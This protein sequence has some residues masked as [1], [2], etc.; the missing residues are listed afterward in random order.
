MSKNINPFIIILIIILIIISFIVLLKW[1]NKQTQIGSENKQIQREEQSIPST[2]KLTNA[3]Q[4]ILDMIT[5]Q[6]LP[7]GE[8]LPILGN[9]VFQNAE[10]NV[11]SDKMNVTGGIA[12]LNFDVI[13]VPTEVKS[14]QREKIQSV[15]ND[16]NIQYNET[17]D[18]PSLQTQKNENITT[19]LNKLIDNSTKTETNINDIQQKIFD[20]YGPE[21]LIGS[22]K[23]D[24]KIDNYYRRRNILNNDIIY[25]K[26]PTYTIQTDSSSVY[27]LFPQNRSTITETSQI[28][29]KFFKTESI[30][31]NDRIDD[32][33]AKKTKIT[34]RPVFYTMTDLV[35]QLKMDN[36]K[37]DLL[38]KEEKILGLRN[39]GK[40]I[41]YK[42]LTFIGYINKIY[43]TDETYNGYQSLL[44]VF[45]KYMLPEVI[46]SIVHKI[47][48]INYQMSAYVNNIEDEEKSY[49][50]YIIYLKPS[51][52]DY[53]KKKYVDQYNDSITIFPL[54]QELKFN[55]NG[56]T[57]QNYDSYGLDPTYLCLR[58]GSFV[59]NDLD[60]VQG[61]NDYISTMI[62]KS[63]IK[64]ENVFYKLIKVEGLDWNSINNFMNQLST[65]PFVFQLSLHIL[66]EF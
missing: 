38:N 28:Q 24:N 9:K 49:N 58:I 44:L 52:S 22:Y 42:R 16:Y 48:G 21:E 47:Y 10:N 57:K 7:V 18:L 36:T 51:I 14:I 30:L 17:S 45:G 26:Q 39:L 13:K 54:L 50:E 29:N 60:I 3:K 53:L 56:I 23:Y 55:M 41:I 12:T 66:K 34:Q 11:I 59:A 40:M 25:Y 43:L 64:I 27:N 31:N 63:N 20:L 19:E 61:F 46:K 6:S 65:Y 37:T 4:N 35:K 15:N 2:F 32:V 5:S 33:S 62:N 8:I 1:S